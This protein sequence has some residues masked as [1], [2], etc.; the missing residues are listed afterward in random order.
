MK[1]LNRTTRKINGK[2]HA[3]VRYEDDNGKKGE[4]LRR[5]EGKWDAENLKAKL[6]TELLEKGPAQLVAGKVSFRQL[7]QYA[8]D[9]IY[10]PAVCDENGIESKEGK[11]KNQRI[12]RSMS[13]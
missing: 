9:H 1:I 4:L 8:K 7:V 6:V 3:R 10:V 5:A 11:A 12:M 13:Y 2:W